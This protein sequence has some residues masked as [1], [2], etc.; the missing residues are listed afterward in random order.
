MVLTFQYG[1][2]NI[3]SASKK[4]LE[5]VE[6]E[7]EDEATKSETNQNPEGNAESKDKSGQTV[8]KPNGVL[9]RPPQ[10]GMNS[11]RSTVISRESFVLTP[12]VEYHRNDAK[13]AVKNGASKTVEELDCKKQV[14]C[15]NS[16]S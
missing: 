14:C 15:L 10:N 1:R 9:N 13:V 11:N 12:D 4:R 6:S 3:E 7:D 2:A 8:A 16:Y 5:D